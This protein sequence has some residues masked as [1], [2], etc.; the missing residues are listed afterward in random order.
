MLRHL[1]PF[2]YHRPFLPVPRAVVLGGGDN[3]N[4]PNST[5]QNFILSGAK[6]NAR[7]EFGWTV[8]HFS[9]AFNLVEMTRFLLEK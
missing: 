4:L 8:L 6:I 2:A 7:D 5:F 1:P 3:C 9:A